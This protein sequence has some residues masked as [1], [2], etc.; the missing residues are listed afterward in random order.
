MFESRYVSVLT[1][2]ITLHSESEIILPHRPVI[3]SKILLVLK[4]VQKEFTDHNEFY[5]TYLAPVGEGQHI[6]RL[7]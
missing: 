7:I 2:L 3:C 5:V 4:N 1:K 6:S